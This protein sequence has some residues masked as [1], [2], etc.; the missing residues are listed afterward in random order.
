MSNK[1]KVDFKFKVIKDD[2]TKATYTDS[3]SGNRSDCC[4]RTCKIKEH[5]NTVNQWADYFD[6]NAG[7]IQY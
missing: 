4:T 6:L 5:G 2:L 3:C 1:V 7:M